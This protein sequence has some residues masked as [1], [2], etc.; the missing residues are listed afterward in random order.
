MR[1]CANTTLL[2]T[3]CHFS[4]SDQAL[5][6]VGALLAKHWNDPYLFNKFSA[7]TIQ[8]RPRLCAMRTC[9]HHKAASCS[10]LR[11][12]QSLLYAVLLYQRV[13]CV[14]ARACCKSALLAENIAR[15]CSSR[16]FVSDL[17]MLIS[18]PK[19]N[20]RSHLYVRFSYE[21]YGLPRISRDVLELE[22]FPRPA[23]QNAAYR[24]I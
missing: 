22:N 15:P 23:H 1:M 21:D 11:P 4:D 19:Q 17:P 8:V 20:Q 10:P 2:S 12:H 14:F 13:L 5:D 24:H 3:R 7:G 18:G 6:A 16:S 9:V